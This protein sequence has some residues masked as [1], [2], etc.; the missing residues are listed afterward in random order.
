[1]GQRPEVSG[2]SALARAANKASTLH[3]DAP[4]DGVEPTL[5]R[6]LDP[7]R[8]TA[9]LLPAITVSIHTTNC[10]AASSIVRKSL[11]PSVEELQLFVST[12][13]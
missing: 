7:T 10:M 3:R 6:I 2:L 4:K 11:Q 12:S 8:C 1:M 9:A 5:S 13:I